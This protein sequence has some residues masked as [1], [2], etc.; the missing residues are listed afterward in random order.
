M[1]VKVSDNASCLYILSGVL[2]LSQRDGFR[3]C[4]VV[5]RLQCSPNLPVM[6]RPVTVIRNPGNL[7]AL[8]LI[9]LY[10]LQYT[11]AVHKLCGYTEIRVGLWKGEQRVL[12]M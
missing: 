6:N 4:W 1:K 11:A 10:S 9:H 5:R 7:S 8:I 12:L 3:V 2:S